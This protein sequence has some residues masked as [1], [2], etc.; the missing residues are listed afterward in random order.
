MSAQISTE[1]KWYAIQCLSNHEDKV[2]RYLCKY[3]EENEEFAQCLNEILVPIETVSE[4]KNGKKRQRDR[5]FY[6]GYVFVEMKLFDL[7]GNLL[8]N[9]WYK[10]KETD[11]VINFIGR[12]NPTPL[13]EDEIGRIL[14]QVDD[15]KGKEVPKVKFGKGEVVKILDGPFLNLTGEIEDIDAE[16]GTL[17]VSVS[18]FGRFTPVELEFWQVEKADEE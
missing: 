7:Q 17:K 1:L 9:P 6:P 12:E 4:V 11:G 15:A 18:I 13:G 14:R 16:K 10:V 2:R 5:K 3:K 8:K